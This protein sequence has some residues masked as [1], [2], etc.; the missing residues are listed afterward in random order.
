MRTLGK[1][2]HIRY[3]APKAGNQHPQERQRV[4]AAEKALWRRRLGFII[5]VLPI[6][7]VVWLLAT[8]CFA[9]GRTAEGMVQGRTMTVTAPAD[10]RVARLFC[11][12]GESV[13]RG[14][15]LAQ[16]EP[17]SD[18]Q[19]TVL[20][21]RL[22]KSRVRLKLVEAGANLDDINTTG[23]QDLLIEAQLQL[24]LASSEVRR[25]RLDADGLISSRQRLAAALRQDSAKKQG[26]L[27]VLTEQLNEAQARE[28]QSLTQAQELTERL[29]AYQ[30]LQSQ[31]IMSGRE[32]DALR[33]QASAA[34]QDALARRSAIEALMQACEAAGQDRTLEAE[35][36]SAALSELDAAVATSRASMDL[37]RKQ[38]R[39]WQ[40]TVAR[41]RD[42]LPAKQSSPKELLELE[43]SLVRS[44][45]A[46]REAI[47]AAH[48]EKVGRR[49]LVATTDGVIDR[50]FVCEGSVVAPDTTLMTYFDPKDLWVEIYIPTKLA[51]VQ[52][53]DEVQLLPETG[54]EMRT[55]TI[56]SIGKIWI[57]PPSLLTAGSSNSTQRVLPV[58]VQTKTD[59]LQPNLRVQ[60]VFPW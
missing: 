44:E 24:Q 33:A 16:L 2:N 49:T 47:L 28:T 51:D 41:R 55:G 3:A 14:Q 31:G 36:S 4:R 6:I 59:G 39:S 10:V 12:A 38:E 42:S 9:W 57:S 1:L 60:A 32:V 34:R 19:R 18:A 7:P 30:K 56:T 25:T 54:G 58:Q 5:P 27:A 29:A 45:I 22:A 50:V 52:L 13:R 35:R 11:S 21:K 20:E 43:L 8:I 53:G 40:D 37:A 15:P 23:R 17:I 26:A 48:D 46:E